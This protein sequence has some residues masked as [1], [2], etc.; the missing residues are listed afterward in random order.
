MSNPLV[1]NIY[2]NGNDFDGSDDTDSAICSIY[3]HWDADVSCAMVNAQELIK[4]IDNNI[5]YVEVIK[6][7]ISKTNI[8]FGCNDTGEEKE[9]ALFFEKYNVYFDYPKEEV[10]RNNGLLYFSNNGKSESFDNAISVAQ[11]FLEDKI[12]NFDGCCWPSEND[13]PPGDIS[14]S[15]LKMMVSNVNKQ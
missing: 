8:R 11:I 2:K 15:V 1:I 5:K 9:R 14:F 7:I 3:Y 10:N 6:S 4:S 12:V 13:D